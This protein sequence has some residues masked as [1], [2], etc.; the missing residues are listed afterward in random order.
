[1]SDLLARLVAAGTPADLVGEVAML[2]AR[3]EVDREAIETRRKADRERQAARRHVTSRDITGDNVMSQDVTGAAPSL[4]KETLPPTPPIKEI[5]L[6]PTHT[7]GDAPAHARARG[8]WACPDGVETAH[9]RDFMANRTR[10]RLTNTETA[11]LGQLRLLERFSCAEWP[12]GALVQRAA[13]KGWGTIVDPAEYETPRNGQ[14]PANDH[15]DG[16]ANP[17][18]QPDSFPGFG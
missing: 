17:F 7:G 18:Y 12:P 16:P 5:N 3:A 15:R 1:M 14:R 6:T 9:W 10:K 13:E 4:D 2:I 8:T 11:Y